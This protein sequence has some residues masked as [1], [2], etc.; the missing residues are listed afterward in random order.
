MHIGNVIDKRCT[1]FRIIKLCSP[2]VVSSIS[3]LPCE[4][5]SDPT[6]YLTRLNLLL[7]HELERAGVF[8]SR[9][10]RLLFFNDWQL[11]DK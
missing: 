9:S 5:S 11:I 7:N 8:E 1:A 2:S 10:R 3:K 6:V 4:H